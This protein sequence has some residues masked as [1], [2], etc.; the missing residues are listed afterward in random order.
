M[1][2]A[3]AGGSRGLYEAYSALLYILDTLAATQR[4]QPEFG[5]GAACFRGI[6]SWPSFE[7]SKSATPAL[8]M[9][10]FLLVLLDKQE[11]SSELH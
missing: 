1:F 4:G 2:L 6:A 9:E 7:P 11:T 3:R 5:L 10:E 8:H